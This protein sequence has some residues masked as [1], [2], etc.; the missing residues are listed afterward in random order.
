MALDGD[1]LLTQY[2]Y[3]TLIKKSFCEYIRKRLTCPDEAIV[4][5]MNFDATA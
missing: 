5:P 1:L 3:S 4:S 2:L